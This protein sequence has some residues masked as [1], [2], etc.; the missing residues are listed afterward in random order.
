MVLA[1]LTGIAGANAAAGPGQHDHETGAI[2]EGEPMVGL[3]TIKLLSR[4]GIEPPT[5]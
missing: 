2:G 4:G 3:P 5:R 1:V